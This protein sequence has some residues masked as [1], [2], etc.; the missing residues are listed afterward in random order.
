MFFGGSKQKQLVGLDI[1]SSSIK[2]VELKAGRQGYELVSYGMEALAQDTV[3][4]GAIMDAPLV[5]TGISN[6][7]EKQTVEDEKRRDG[8]LRT[9]GDR[10][11]RTAAADDRGRALRPDRNGSATAHPV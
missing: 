5:A 6:I 3:V 2:A 7:F 10:E 1:G 4:D 9:F 8:G 11:A